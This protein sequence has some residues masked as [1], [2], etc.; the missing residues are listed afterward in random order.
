MSSL[1]LQGYGVESSG[2]T[3]PC[4]SI[5]VAGSLESSAQLTLQPP[6]VNLPWL[7]GAFPGGEEPG[8]DDG[9]T[10]CGGELWS[11][12]RICVQALL[13]WESTSWPTAPGEC[14]SAEDG[15]QQAKSCRMHRV[16][17]DGS[18]ACHPCLMCLLVYRRNLMQ[19]CCH[20]TFHSSIC[21][22]SSS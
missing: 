11:A 16:W 18:A 12:L 19:S 8:A 14:P 2:C 17:C 7:P 20:L 21:D 5:S 9:L 1:T 22:K 10:A 15:C 13:H 3:F 6:A 4:Q